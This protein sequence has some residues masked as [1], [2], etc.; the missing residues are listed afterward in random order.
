LSKEIQARLQ[1]QLSRRSVWEQRQRIWYEMAR[2][3]LPRRNKPFPGAANLHLP[4]GDN[5]VEKLKPFYDNSVFSRQT[6]AAFTPLDNAEQGDSSA[7]AAEF[8]DWKLRKESNYPKA[9]GFLIHLMLVG[10]RA[11]LKV[12]WE[13]GRQEGMGKLAFDAIDPLYFIPQAEKDDPAEMDLF[14]HVQ[15]L[16]VEAYKRRKQYTEQ[17]E[18]V[19]KVIRGGENQAS[20]YKDQEREFREGLNGSTNKELIVLWE[21]WER[22]ENGFRVRTFSPCQ[23]DKPVRKD[24][25][26]PVK[27]RG[28]R[29]QPFVAVQAELSE[30]GW[31]SPRGVVEKVAPYE[32][33]GTK[34]WNQKADWLEYSA[35][36]LFERDASAAMPNTAGNI[37]LRPGEMLPPG[38]KPAAMPA[39]PFSL[40]EEINVCRQLAEE[41]V[42]VPDFGVTPEGDSKDTRTAT[43][44]QYIGSFASQG[45]Q[46]RARVNGLF[47]GQIYRTAWA[48]LVHYGKKELTYFSAKSRKVL[49]AQALHDNYLIEPDATPDAWNRT[50]RLQRSVARFQMLKGHPNINQE[51][52]VKSILEDDDP[53]LVKKLF[54]SSGAKAANEAEDEAI[55]IMILLEGFPAAA[56]PGEDHQTRLRMLFGKLQQLSMMPPPETP[57]EFQRVAIGRQRMHEHIGQHMQLLQ[58]ENPALAKQFAAAIQAVEG[59]G[60]GGV[61]GR[62]SSV[63]GQP[64]SGAI[65]PMPT[66]QMPAAPGMPPAGAAMGAGGGLV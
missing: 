19:I 51:E 54:L 17:D 23:P 45:I 10:G 20:L 36:P 59:A 11:V 29:I 4:I 3:G 18:D 27:W 52:L 43:E 21:A 61:E 24:F 35:K 38:V 50:Q 22:V 64:G 7:A 55:E 44:M 6:L 1:E 49:P 12:R 58:Q 2:D 57:E 60:G 30:S 5:A 32:A 33:Y 31:Y 48:Y 13:P 14:C 34:L 62:G 66:P 15:Q 41:S 47:E 37:M 25:I 8:L 16:S 26:F 56:L 63:E 53:R 65:V 28:E 42:Q 40:D 46:Y 9:Y 39:P